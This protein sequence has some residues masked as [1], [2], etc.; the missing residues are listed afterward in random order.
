MKCA[1]ETLKPS[2]AYN[3]FMLD[4]SMKI[5]VNIEALKNNNKSTI[6]RTFSEHLVNILGTF[7][8]LSVNIQG[9]FSEFEKGTLYRILHASDRI[10]VVLAIK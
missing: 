2:A 3:N 10:F 5:N 6:Q 8:E 1:Q 9:T 4:V 7:R